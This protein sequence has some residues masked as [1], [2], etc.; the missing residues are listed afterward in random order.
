MQKYFDAEKAGGLLLAVLGIAGLCLASYLWLGRSSFKA[1]AWPLIVIGLIEVGIGVGL[2]IRTGPQVQALEAGLQDT[3]QQT[4]A[5][6][7]QRMSRVNRSFR[8]II[9]VVIVVMVAGAL[10]A[11]VLRGTNL[12]WTAVSLGLVLQAAILLA[13]DVFAEQR[14][15]GYVRWLETLQ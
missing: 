14:A 9:R 5:S 2:A 10:V 12:D 8:V 4:A 3:R 15:H 1:M 6:E 7:I 13:F 11:F